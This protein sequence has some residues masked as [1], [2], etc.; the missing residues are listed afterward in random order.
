MEVELQHDQLITVE[1]AHGRQLANLHD[2]SNLT[3]C[4]E[5]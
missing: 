4:L 3:L 5:L 2:K 1:D